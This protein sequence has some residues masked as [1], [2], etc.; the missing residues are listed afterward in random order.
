MLCCR[1]DHGRILKQYKNGL[2]NLKQEAVETETVYCLLYKDVIRLWHLCTRWWFHGQALVY[3]AS[4]VATQTLEASRNYTR[5]RTLHTDSREVAP[6]ANTAKLETD[7]YL[8]RYESELENS[9]RLSAEARA[10]M[11]AVDCLLQM[12]S[13]SNQ[14]ELHDISE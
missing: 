3:N 11:H 7:F 5:N 1:I 6:S 14:E 4:Y 9:A 10:L 13:F 12:A 2:L 8:R